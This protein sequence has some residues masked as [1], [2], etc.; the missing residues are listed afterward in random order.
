M[1]STGGPNKVIGRG[2]VV[3]F[4]TATN[5]TAAVVVRL[6]YICVAAF[7]YFYFSMIGLTQFVVNT[8]T[9]FTPAYAQAYI[10]GTAFYILFCCFCFECVVLFCR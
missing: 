10:I 2:S 3:L 9:T 4:S 5:S 7:S 8:G 6:A 1:S